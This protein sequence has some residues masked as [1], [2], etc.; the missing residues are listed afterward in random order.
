MKEFLLD[1]EKDTVEGAILG[2]V[3]LGVRAGRG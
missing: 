2:L 1:W 3:E